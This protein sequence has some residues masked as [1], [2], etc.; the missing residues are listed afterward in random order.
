VSAIDLPPGMGLQGTP[1]AVFRSPRRSR[2]LAWIVLVSVLVLCAVTWYLVY[3]HPRRSG[4]SIQ[5]VVPAALV[6]F[7]AL[8]VGVRSARLAISRNGVRWGWSSFGFTQQ[9]SRVAKAHVYRDGVTLQA[10]RGSW[11][12]LAARDWDGFA[13]LVR[14]LRRTEMTIEDHDRAAPY[15]ARMQ[16]YGRFL[17]TMLVFAVVGA[18]AIAM[19]AS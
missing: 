17:D 16:S 6:L 14:Q 5:I 1:L 10:K 18:F 12:F 8:G 4:A 11:W 2:A 9:A 13:T 7:G 3:Q 15:R 19:W